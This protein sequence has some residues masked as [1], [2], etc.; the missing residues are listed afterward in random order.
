VSLGT[1]SLDT[2]SLDESTAIA[3]HLAPL[4]QPG[5][6]ARADVVVGI[7]DDGAV[8]RPPP[9]Q[10]LVLTTDTLAEG[11]DFPPGFPPGDIAWRALA[12]NLSDLAAMGATPAWAT[13]ALTAPGLA[14]DWLAAFA[15][16]FRALAAPHGLALVGGDLG[17]GPLS[18][19]L[20]L[21]GFVPAGQALRRSGAAPGDLLF[22]SGTLG[23]A[24]LGLAILLGRRPAPDSAAEAGFLY[25][26]FARPE[27]RIAL[28]ERLRGIASSAIDCSDGLVADLG[29]LL[30]ASGVGALIQLDRLPLSPALRALPPAEAWGYACGGGD[31]YELLFTCPPPRRAALVAALAGL[32]PTP[33]AIATE[34]GRIAQGSGLGLLA[35]DG[36]PWFPP[37]TGY[38]HF[39]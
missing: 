9:G 24:A 28:G 30:T 12:A 1:L 39:S 15:A 22:A 18:L 10:D 35:P 8:L 2:L 4:G 11:T 25:R 3:R 17:R 19:T 13:L 32:A 21:A 27:P 23:D 7:G 36:Q 37:A 16:G 29:H 5:G 34:I 14:D 38:Q 33:L 6:G 31:D 20:T 26:R